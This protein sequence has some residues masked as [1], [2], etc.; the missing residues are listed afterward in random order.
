MCRIS[1]LEKDLYYY[2]MTSREFKKKLR[3]SRESVKN[4]HDDRDVG[5]ADVG[6]RDIAAGGDAA[7]SLHGLSYHRTHLSLCFN[8]IICSLQTSLDAGYS[9]ACLVVCVFICVCLCVCLSLSMFVTL[10]KPAKTTEPIKM[11]V[12]GWA[13]HTCTGPKN[14]VLDGDTY[15]HYLANMIEIYS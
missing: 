7:V 11:L 5:G 10:V 1:E 9:S 8:V 3:L 14:C 6:G 2:K 4:E 13:C 12:W 15:R